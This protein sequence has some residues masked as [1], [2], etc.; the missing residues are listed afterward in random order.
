ME[1]GKIMSYFSKLMGPYIS[2]CFIYK[3]DWKHLFYNIC[4]DT[5]PQQSLLIVIYFNIF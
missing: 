5:L 2:V 4:S 1:K 3:L